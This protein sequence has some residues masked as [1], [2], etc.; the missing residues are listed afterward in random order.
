MRNSTSILKAGES[1]MANNQS[2]WDYFDYDIFSQY[3]K[4]PRLFI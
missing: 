3:L 2:S 1:I 4:Q